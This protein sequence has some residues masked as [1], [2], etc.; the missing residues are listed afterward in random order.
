MSDVRNITTVFL[1]YDDLNICNE[2]R[3]G[4]SAGVVPGVRRQGARDAQH[5]DG[6]GSI[7]P[8]GDS[9]VAT[10]I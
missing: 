9:E 3:V 4:H 5:G 8:G 7:T 1:L 2:I 6:R 10:I